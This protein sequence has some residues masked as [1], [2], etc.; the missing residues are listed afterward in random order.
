M[1]YRFV[2]PEVH[3]DDQAIFLRRP[4]ELRQDP[5]YLV[6][7]SAKRASRA[8]TCATTSASLLLEPPSP[9]FVPVAHCTYTAALLCAHYCDHV[10]KMHTS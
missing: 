9:T 6:Q 8:L 3:D 2:V 10:V 5:A 7:T 4:S 1:F